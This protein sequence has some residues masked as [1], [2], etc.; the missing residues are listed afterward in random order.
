MDTDTLERARAL[1]RPLAAP[2]GTGTTHAQ[3]SAITGELA[4]LFG[5]VPPSPSGGAQPMDEAVGTIDTRV[6]VLVLP[7]EQVRQ[8]LP[9]GLE[10]APQPVVPWGWHP[11]FVLCSHDVFKPWFATMDYQEIMIGVPWVQ[12][13]HPLAPY[14]GPFIYMPRLYLNDLL[15]CE[16]GVHLYG[17]EKQM[18]T[19]AVA[20][21]PGLA[22]VIA[23]P[24]GASAPVLSGTFTE[25]AGQAPQPA[26]AFP[27]AT[28]VRQLFEQPTISQALHIVDPQSFDSKLPG[29]FLGS[30]VVLQFD[31]QGA[32]I[33]PI[34][35]SLTIDA[36]LTPAGIPPGTYSSAGLDSTPLGAFRLQCVQVVS[37]PGACADVV[38]PRPAAT[39]KLKVAVLGGGPAA[40]AAALQLA[41]QPDRYEVSVY[42]QGHRLGGKCQSWRNP[43]EG[44]RIEEHGLHALLGFYE[45]A[46][47]VVQLAYDHA[48]ETVAKGEVLYG[49]AFIPEPNNGT[50]VL[51]HGQWTYCP[52]PLPSSASPNASTASGAHGSAMVTVLEAL[53]ERVL[54]YVDAATRESPSSHVLFLEVEAA[55][56]SLKTELM[57]VAIRLVDDLSKG[58]LE[59]IDQGLA[60]MLAASRD[61]LALLIHHNPFVST[62]LWFLWNGIDTMLTIFV[63]L[64]R[65]PV[66]NLA[67]LD[68]VDFRDWLRQNGLHEDADESWSCIDQVYET[69]FAHQLAGAQCGP[70]ITDVKPASLA[71]GV[72]MRWFLLESF[73][74]HGAPAYR[75]EYSCA[76]TMMTPF[77]LALQRL[78]AR[79]HFFHQVTGLAVSGSGVE[80]GLTSIALVQQAEVTAGSDRYAPLIPITVPGNPPELPDWPMEPHWSQLTNGPQLKAQG[81]DFD[82]MW[83][84]AGARFARPLVLQRGRDFDLCV[85]GIPLGAL[86]LIDSPLT[87]P[88]RSDADPRWAAMANGTAL[89]QT[90]SF[91]L[92]LSTAASQLISGKTRGLLTCF[93]EPE[94]SYGDFTHLLSHENWKVA[95]PK[96]VAYFTG[97]SVSGKP[98]LPPDCGSNYPTQAHQAWAVQVEAWLRA[99]YRLFFD[100]PATP[101]TFEGF[102]ELLCTE[103]STAQGVGRLLAQHL[104]ADVQPSNLYVL[105]QPSPKP[106]RL[107]QGESAVGGLILCG[108]WTRTD[109]NCGCVEAATTSGLLA[110]RAISNEPRSYWRPGF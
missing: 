17:F 65:H 41:A 93:A 97:S 33:Q 81:V 63:G 78:G 72:A 90:M 85:L 44:W 25:I 30:T 42:T 10:L 45:N 14:P 73:G 34:T 98:P 23:T 68:S 70:L 56:K 89:T 39:R 55:V 66:S 77:Y 29:P 60:A 82:D 62:Y 106:V 94:P 36:G 95:T 31:G 105:S 101:S 21:M 11:V 7:S 102:L 80:R 57:S 38:Y 9:A 69:L 91:Q 18:A 4:R 24:E 49:Q 51:R 88:T 8:L 46:F 75:F 5:H 40:C 6:T 79:V 43:N 59:L 50:M 87:Q 28:I 58:P 67:E 108:D 86:P 61:A 109:M 12:M 22:T 54:T 74:Y 84:T 110:A 35:A 53:A 103:D 26:S 83:S 99:N 96:Y 27:N 104:I 32:T 15:P 37:L 19:I 92:W 71:C 1:A 107:G 47:T 13:T 2:A 100:G 16:M 48:F 3:A 52:S 64:L 20:E 76:Q